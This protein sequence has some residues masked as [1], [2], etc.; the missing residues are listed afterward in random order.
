MSAETETHSQ[1][2]LWLWH[3]R[4]LSI[5]PALFNPQLLGH[6]PAYVTEGGIL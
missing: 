6:D 4:R 5:D 2:L 1:N 3:A